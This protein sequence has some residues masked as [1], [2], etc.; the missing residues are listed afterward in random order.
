M[1]N[2][3][4]SNSTKIKNKK[5]ENEDKKTLTLMR[6]VQKVEAQGKRGK[7]KNVTTQITN[8]LLSYIQTN[9]DEYSLLMLAYIILGVLIS[10]RKIILNAFLETDSFLNDKLG[11][12][13]LKFSKNK[14]K[15]THQKK[16]IQ[17]K[18]LTPE[19][20]RTLFNKT[21]LSEFEKVKSNKFHLSQDLFDRIKNTIFK[22]KL[23]SIMNGLTQEDIKLYEEEKILNPLFKQFSQPVQKFEKKLISESN[24]N[25]QNFANYVGINLDSIIN[26]EAN[27]EMEIIDENNYEEQYDNFSSPQKNIKFELIKNIC[28]ENTQEKS[29]NYLR[30]DKE[31]FE[32]DIETYLEMMRDE[33]DMSVY[34][35]KNVFTRNLDRVRENESFKSFKEKILYENFHPIKDCKNISIEPD[36]FE[37]ISNNLN[38][39][40]LEK[41]KLE[42]TFYG[43]GR[44][45]FSIIHNEKNEF[46]S[47]Q[48]R[49]DDKS[50]LSNS[51]NIDINFNENPKNNN[52]VVKAKT[53]SPKMNV[54]PD[55]NT[56]QYNE[57]SQLSGGVYDEKEEKIGIEM[58]GKLKEI[59]SECKYYQNINVESL[60]SL[61]DKKCNMLNSEFGENNEKLKK[62][63]LFYNLLLCCQ[64]NGIN[65]QQNNLFSD[66]FLV[67][68]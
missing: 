67:K 3:Q 33:E 21:L 53:F 63:F 62:S 12:G 1:S 65:L 8:E 44:D 50:N 11:L 55:V 58:I 6:S 68:D 54:F 64:A 15:T 43:N 38:N 45:Y 26:K 46:S 32:Y 14:S 51:Q 13:K 60:M 16:K 49:L 23:P 2:N 31:F 35:M 27:F 9:I 24:K 5:G 52:D 25:T 66:F 20:L 19:T 34:D 10:I 59:I 57:L 37:I 48:Q 22:M 41:F 4:S 39:Q 29:G 47:D 40:L 18:N 56:S 36:N 7:I 42:Y 30:K 61:L 17:G 28:D